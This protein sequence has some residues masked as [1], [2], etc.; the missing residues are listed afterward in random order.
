MPNIGNNNHNYAKLSTIAF[1]LYAFPAKTLV[2]NLDEPLRRG[3]QEFAFTRNNAVTALGEILIDRDDAHL[4]L[5]FFGDTD[6]GDDR[7]PLPEAD[8]ALD[9]FPA[10]GLERDPEI[11]VVLGK[12]HFYD[13]PGAEVA[14][15]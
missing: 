1:S 5:V 10:T 15:R 6:I 11:D 3:G 2:H 8:V 4:A 14:R 9:D 13:M 7:Y 12:H